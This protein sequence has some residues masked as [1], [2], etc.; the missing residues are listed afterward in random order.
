M[1]NYNVYIFRPDGNTDRY[2]CV[3]PDTEDAT[4]IA[5]KK[6]RSDIQ[7]LIKRASPGREKR[8]W[9]EVT[10]GPSPSTT[11]YRPARHSC[12]CKRLEPLRQ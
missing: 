1:P 12:C 11:G 10:G 3:A 2:N 6:Y 7:S 8:L 4:A 5:A 9:E